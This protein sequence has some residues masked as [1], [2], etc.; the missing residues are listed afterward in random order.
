MVSI[1][2]KVSIIE[3]TSL[4]GQLN[5][6]VLKIN[7]SINIQKMKRNSSQLLSHLILSNLK[8]TTLYNI[9]IEK[10]NGGEGSE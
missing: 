9:H 4:D 7:M 6:D 10:D 1:N 8:V 3:L 2:I 5:I